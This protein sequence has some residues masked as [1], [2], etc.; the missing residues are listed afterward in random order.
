MKQ[1]ESTELL[2]CASPAK[3]ESKE[4]VCFMVANTGQPMTVG[5]YDH[6]VVLDLSGATFEKN[7]SPVLFYHEDW[8]PIGVTTEQTVLAAG[9]TGTMGTRTLTEGGVYAMWK[10]TNSGKVAAEVKENIENG[11]PYEVSVGAMPLEMLE[12]ARGESYEVNG[13]NLQ[14]PAYVATRSSIKEVSICVFGACPGTAN[15]KAA[16]QRH[17]KKEKNMEENSVNNA[18]ISA[19]AS[20]DV[21]EKEP[22]KTPEPIQAA[23]VAKPD[24]Q[25]PIQ[26]KQEDTAE[27]MRRLSI[28]TIAK[29][30]YVPNGAKVTL[31][32]AEFKTVKAAQN[33]ALKNGISADA[34]Q[35]ACIEASLNRSVGPVVHTSG[36]DSNRSQIVQASALMNLGISGDWLEKKGGF[37]PSCVEA[38]DRE[39]RDVSILSLMGEA[40]K[41]TGGSV[42]YRNP[43]RIVEDYKAIHASNVS[44]SDYGDINVFSPII[45][46]QMRYRYE[47]LDS[48]WQRLYRRRVVTDFKD[49]ATV[50]FTV[51]G[52]AKDLV[53]N[54]DFPQVLLTSSGAKFATGKQGIIAGI[55]FESQVNDD[56]G[57]LSVV[58]S[59]LVNLIYEEH[60]EKFW[61]TFWGVVSSNYTTGNK[62]KTTK[63]LS[64][65]GLS[66]AK[67]LFGGLKNKAGHFIHVVPQ[68]LLV[69][70]A[71]EDVANNLFK[72]P[73][74]GQNNT[75]GNVHVG[76]YEVVTDPYLGAEG[77]ITGATDTGWFMVGDTQR[78]P[79]GEFVVL[80]GFETPGVKETWY[81]HKDALNIRALGTI[82][83]HAYTDKLCAVY[84]DGTVS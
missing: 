30:A 65:A 61:N 34:F 26:A 41:A 35:K 57:A 22:A 6:P 82:G 21:L 76:K 40:I 37:T 28:D 42:D 19:S 44:T 77:G 9:Q 71:L 83:F 2:R 23:A 24:T 3:I 18:P 15:V 73:W 49:V 54:E 32:E 1:I 70:L 20:P 68:F 72:W 48:I 11:F 46:K 45:D 59:E 63:A 33:Y 31:D 84:S 10:F 51:K 39:R 27:T 62:N 75:A 81:D 17:N 52:K 4:G 7:P 43:R 55:S 36:C 64:V 13:Y 5:F 50:D 53:E 58:A 80:A 29:S 56:M 25:A 8:L 16:R 79:L 78:Y 47:L 38:A 14:G 69:P 67:K 74:A 60:T 12:L 66:A